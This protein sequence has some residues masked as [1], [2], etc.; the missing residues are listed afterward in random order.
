[1]W[2]IYCWENWIVGDLFWGKKHVA[3]EKGQQSRNRE[4]ETK[5]GGMGQAGVCAARDEKCRCVVGRERKRELKGQARSKTT[6]LWTHIN[7]VINVFLKRFSMDKWSPVPTT[8]TLSVT[9]NLTAL[10][11]LQQ[12]LKPLSSIWGQCLPVKFSPWSLTTILGC[13]THYG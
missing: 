11:V 5:R 9:Q 2:L 6:S 13:Q 12:L 7:R 10:Q 8:V 3:N 1:M 4:R